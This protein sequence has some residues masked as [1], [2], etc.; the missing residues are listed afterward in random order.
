MDTY[1]LKIEIFMFNNENF[2][3]LWLSFIE[4]IY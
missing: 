2:D 1:L 3:I 4:I